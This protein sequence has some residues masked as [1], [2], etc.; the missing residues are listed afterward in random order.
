MYTR[1]IILLCFCSIFSLCPL[2]AEAAQEN[3]NYATYRDLPDITPE[4]IS[5]VERLRRNRSHFVFGAEPST[6][7]FHTVDGTLGGYSVL[8]C[9]WLSTFF[10]IRFTPTMYAWDGLIN[11]LAS[12]AVDFTGELTPTLERRTI[13][14]MTSPLLERNLKYMRI[15]GS[16]NLAEIA[17]SRAVRY[18]FL[19]GTTNFQQVKASLEKPFEIFQTDNHA[20]A[21]RML[22]SNAIDAF[23]EEAPYEASFDAYG[24]IVSEDILP[25][26]FAPVSLATQNPELAPIISIV[27]KALD[28]GGIRHLNNLSRQGQQAYLRHKFLAGLTQ[29]EREYVHAHSKYGRN[30]PVFIGMEY[31]NYPIAFYNEREKEW[32]GCAVDILEA[33]GNISG[34]NFTHAFQT[35]TL[36]PEMLR[37]LENGKPA[38]VS[39]LVKTPER[40]GLFLW[41]EK[42]Y[43]TD[44]Y[45]LISRAGYPNVELSDVRYLTVG[46]SKDT[47]FTELFRQWF[48]EHKHTKEYIDMLEPF[49][50]LERGEV[51]LVMSSQNQLLS[52]TNYMERPYFRINISFNRKFESYFGINK[53]ETILCA[54]ISK[55][56]GLVNADDIAERWKRRV[57]DYNGAVARARMP[58]LIAGLTLFLCV[59]VLLSVMFLKSKRTGKKL[60]A[61]VEERTRALQY[62]TY[63]AE[64]A[65]KAKGD[66]LARMSHEIRTPMNAI[67][68]MSELA[69]RELVQREAV[70]GEAVQRE[71]VQRE[72]EQ[73]QQGMQKALEYITGIKNAGASLLTIINDILDFSKIES[74]NLPIHPA[75]YETASL[76][77]D[78]LTIIR[79]K[80]AETPLELL[81]DTSSDIPRR[82]I[83][84][85]G[86][87]KQVLLNLLG[88]AVKYTKKGFIKFSVSGEPVAEDAVL[89]TFIVED[90]GIGIKDEDLP[91]LFGEFMRFDEKRNSRIEGTGLGLVISRNL[92][93]AMGGD[94]TARSEYGRGALFTA[95]LQQNV[96]EWEP[97]GDPADM[98]AAL[99]ETQRVTFNAPEAEVL[100]VDD[101]AGNLLVAEGLLAPYGMRVSLCLNGREAVE[102]I[103]VRS[104]DLVLMDHMMPEMDGV[105]TTG[106]IRAMPEE[107]C[108]ALPVIAL[109]ANAVTGM[110]EMFLENGFNDFLSKPIETAKLDALL[111]KWIPADKRREAQDDVSQPDSASVAL[112][113]RAL[114]EIAGVDVAV[115]IARIGGSQR[116]YLELLEMFC[117]DVEAGSALLEKEPP[118]TDDRSEQFTAAAD[119]APDYA[120][121][122]PFTILVHALKSGLANIGAEVLSRHAAVLE[123]AGREADLPM[124]RD[125][126][127]PFR[128]ELAALTA[129]LAEVTAAARAVDEGRHAGRETGAVLAQ[130]HEALVA[131]DIDAICA[132]QAQLQALPLTGKTL[133]A[134]SDIADCI[135]TMEFRKASDAV[136]VLLRQTD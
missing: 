15:A 106:I 97:M 79:V 113:E 39:E 105:E 45:V 98:A 132:A 119:S 13:Y 43:M 89:L 25:M 95:T 128:E 80:L 56:L 81:L 41:P 50:A 44:S 53:S 131:K 65:V 70:Q 52:M 30:I 29:E 17:E 46:M 87:I 100:I 68:G 71:A 83:G 78:V 22:K 72:S 16:R 129:R 1:C 4:E 40:E 20:M 76:L 48:P 12:H 63:V 10:G 107:R 61:A 118:L 51:D 112:P 99:A 130:L 85:A 101:F 14:L 92:C 36:W 77:N 74:G 24:D 7:L 120:A 54:I 110:K 117:R 21:Y 82:M 31:D 3:F 6:E 32:Q 5:A 18:G 133:D 109:T 59:I 35:P 33:V 123:K 104:F 103:R 2:Q 38:L 125:K 19:T 58:Y 60:E 67:I 114:P 108:R 27:Q 126:L 9:D 42:P 111:Q 55:S 134:V 86:R 88:N 122:K 8:L 75:P 94:I 116:R 57:F 84:D 136:A 23:V 34:L 37:M 121:L 93:R 66:F 28:N 62:Q 64:Q 135:L 127:P 115:G 124:I 26:V 73:R 102:L 69:Q 90:S 49:F 91:K 11:G 96:A 47:A